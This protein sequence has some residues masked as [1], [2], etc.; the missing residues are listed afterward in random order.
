MNRSFT[1]LLGP[2]L[3]WL[4]LS[5]LAHV[6]ASRNQPTTEAGNDQLLTL[7]WVLPFGAILLSF[8]SLAWAPG[9]S[10]W[11][12]LRIGLVGLFGLVYLT[13]VLCGAIDYHDSRNSG[14]GTGFIMYVIFGGFFLLVG[15][16]ITALFLLTRWN[17][18]PVLK[19]SLIILGGLTAFFS[20]V[21]WI[22]SFGKGAEG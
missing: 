20:L 8:I 18:M 13:N 5:V 21:F 16:A 4:L 9:N 17:F 22:A 6:L 7:A 3:I 10:W 14:V 11:W 15:I 2:E 1:H 19:W 12:L